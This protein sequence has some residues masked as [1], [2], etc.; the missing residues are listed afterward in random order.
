MR[1]CHVLIAAEVALLAGSNGVAG[2]V[3]CPETPGASPASW[4][5]SFSFN[6]WNK[7]VSQTNDTSGS[8]FGSW[9]SWFSFNGWNTESP[10]ANG[11]P[12]TAWFPWFSFDNFTPGAPGVDTSGSSTEQQTPAIPAAQPTGAPALPAAQTTDAPEIPTAPTTDIS[13]TPAAQ[14][15]NVPETPAVYPTNAPETPAVQPTSAPETPAPETTD[16]PATTNSPAGADPPSPDTDASAAAAPSAASNSSTTTTSS[17]NSK[18]CA[19]P[20]VRI[21]EVDL[22]VTVDANEDEVNLKV[23]A[24]SALPSGGSRIAFHSGESVVVQELDANDKLVSGSTVKVP[25]HDFA[26]IYADKD[27]FVLLGTRDS[28]GGGTLNCGNPSNLCGSAPS[29]AVPCYDMYLVRYDGS[30]ES[31]ATKLTSSS[32]SLPPYSSGKPGADVYMIW[33]YA[34]HG[35]IASDGTNWAAYF[36]CAISTSEGGCI[37]IHQGDRMKVVD[38]SGKIATQ[39]DSFDWGC[40]H[41]GYER[42]TYDSRKKG[43]TSICKTDSNNRIMPPK[44]WGTT[45]YPVDLGAANLGDIVPDSDAS[46]KKYWATVS[47]G[48][49]D[50]AKVHLIHFAINAAA[51]DDI[52]LGGT[53]ANERAPH[54]AA[55]GDGGLLAMWEGSSSGGDLAEGGARTIYAQILDAST[56]KTIS[57]KVTVDKSVVGNRYQALKS[58]PDGSVAYLSKGT[59]DT[60]VQVVRFFGC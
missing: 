58:F 14:T 6:D 33:W 16:A 31:W 53:D 28:D 36:G 24:I 35:R 51:N 39:A 21:T 45:I 5:P 8:A 3:D 26:D 12:G 29:P 13:E 46:S 60:S 22:G 34:H 17:D 55:I 44:D 27:G 18:L 32:A 38:P 52:T 7:G 47:N 23:V 15:T 59:T 2:T 25:L 49:G 48:E 4:F 43:Y 10:H 50:N 11:A 54:L 19:K 41:S 9:P 57:S 20:R 37:N 1:L 40:S 42:I 56:G 30:K